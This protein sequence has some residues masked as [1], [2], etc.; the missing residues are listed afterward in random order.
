M[1]DIERRRLAWM[2]RRGMRELDVVLSAFLEQRYGRADSGQKAAFRRLLE[3]QDPLIFAYLTGREEPPD[4]P[5]RA[6]LRALRGDT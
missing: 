2:C 6:L 4:A 5:T 1:S 3:C